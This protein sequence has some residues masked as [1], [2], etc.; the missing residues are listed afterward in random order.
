MLF[1]LYDECYDC[2]NENKAVNNKSKGLDHTLS[3]PLLYI[4]KIPLAV[5]RK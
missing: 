2:I 4:R 5:I 3:S 1:L